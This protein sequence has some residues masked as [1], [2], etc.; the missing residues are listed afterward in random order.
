MEFYLNAW[1]VDKEKSNIN[2][3]DIIWFA[4]LLERG[5]K[6]YISLQYS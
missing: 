5:L 1:F 3:L 2:N 4:Y 6:I